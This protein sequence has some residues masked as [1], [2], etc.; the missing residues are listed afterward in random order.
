MKK[1]R[2][3]E[4]DA[5]DPDDRHYAARKADLDGRLCNMYDKIEDVENRL[6]AARARKAAAEAEGI[7]A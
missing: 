2:M 7:T 4:I 3:E 6:L 1:E 5:L